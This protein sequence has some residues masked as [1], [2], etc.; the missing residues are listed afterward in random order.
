LIAVAETLPG[1]AASE[2]NSILVKLGAGAPAN[3]AADARY[4]AAHTQE[5]DAFM[6]ASPGTARRASG[7]LL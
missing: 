4:I 5:I 6:A 1:V 3:A 7:S 2:R